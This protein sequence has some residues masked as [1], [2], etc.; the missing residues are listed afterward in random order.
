MTAQGAARRQ[1]PE[2]GSGILLDLMMTYN[3]SLAA[4]L[5]YPVPSALVARLL[6]RVLLPPA[7]A[8]RTTP[9]ETPLVPQE[10]P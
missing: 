10:G 3:G 6:G 7:G 2:D 1:P 5:W 4:W 8:R 9:T